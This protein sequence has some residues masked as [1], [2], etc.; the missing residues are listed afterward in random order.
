[1]LFQRFG[2]LAARNMLYLQNDLRYLEGRL[3]CVKGKDSYANIGIKARCAFSSY[4]RS[5]S[6][7]K[8]SDGTL[9]DGDIEQRDLDLKIRR[10]LGEYN[11]TYR[12]R[13]PDHA[14]M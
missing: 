7:K 8:N 4:G 11:M 13:A 14:L 5:K 1:M 10:T 12:S 9:R 2:G 6:N 3:R